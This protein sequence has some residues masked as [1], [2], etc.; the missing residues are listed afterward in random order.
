MGKA[1]YMI[2][3]ESYVL[4]GFHSLID[5]P[6]FKSGRFPMLVHV[7]SEANSLFSNPYCLLN[8]HRMKKQAAHCNKNQQKYDERKI[9]RN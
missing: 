5:K 9:S 8:N 7:S 2:L 3:Y 6:L 4:A 1:V